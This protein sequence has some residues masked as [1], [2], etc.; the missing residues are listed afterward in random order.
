VRFADANVVLDFCGL[1]AAHAGRAR[2]V[3]A[4]NV[5]GEPM[6]VTEAVLAE[7]FWVLRTTYGLTPQRSAS[8]L[9]RV[10]SSTDFTFDTQYQ[11]P[12]IKLI[13][14]HPALDITDC[15]LAARALKG[16]GV[17]THD[18]RLKREIELELK[19]RSDV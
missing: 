13:E 6:I 16:H 3:A 19:G 4:A 9:R 11:V 7:C 17:V 12:A 1:T 5:D 18:R 14:R 15:L 2:G 10:T 8:V